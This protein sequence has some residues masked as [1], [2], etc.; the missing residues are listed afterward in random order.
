MT[1]ALSV[2]IPVYNRGELI[3]YTMESLRRASRGIQVETIVVD[4]GSKTPVAEDLAR[5]GHIDGIR[6]L[7]QENRGLLFARLTGFAAATGRYTLFLDS[8]D[9]VA[10]GKLRA[11]IDAMDTAGSD[12]SYTDIA[13][14]ELTGDYDSLIISAD[15]PT[16]AT[17]DIADFFINIQPAPHCPVFRTDYLR[18]IVERPL[19]APSPLYNPVAEIWFYHNAA[20]QPGK[21]IHVPGAFTIGGSHP[22][23]RLTNQWERL[24]VASLAVM[25]AFARTCPDTPATTRVRNFVG[26]KAFA[27]WRRLPRGFSPEFCERQLALWRR[28]AD[29]RKTA[30]L[31]GP[32]FR[33]LSAVLGAER[34]GELMRRRNASY[35][36]C[37]TMPDPDVEAL[38]TALPAP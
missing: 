14:C 20:P 17:D 11:Q 12:V 38:L 36:S 32:V 6:H 10:P 22:G 29:P 15:P 21:V 23:A 28:L 16:R 1:T 7:S 37:R 34:A 2:I 27:S 8:D 4:D 31:G 19:F 13:R 18:A 35:D 3:R 26:E 9:L 25:E 24:G 30:R 33:V 5:L